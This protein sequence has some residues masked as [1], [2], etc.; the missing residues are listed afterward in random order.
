LP[1]LRQNIYDDF[2][3]FSFP[4]RGDVGGGWRIIGGLMRTTD[5]RD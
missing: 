1:R 3:F 5:D 4:L 2:F